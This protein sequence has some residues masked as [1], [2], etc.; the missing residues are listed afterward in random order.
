MSSGSLLPLALMSG[1]EGYKIL[2]RLCDQIDHEG[3]ITVVDLLR[4]VKVE[5]IPIQYRFGWTSLEDF[6]VKKS[7]TGRYELIVPD[8]QLLAK[9]GK[10]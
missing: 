6:Q 3:Y 1:S 5:A 7:R 8:F 2:A 9:N 10:E 4:L